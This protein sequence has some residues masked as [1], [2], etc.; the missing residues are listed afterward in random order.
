MSMWCDHTNLTSIPKPEN[1]VGTFHA[2]ADKSS[3]LIF[4]QSCVKTIDKSEF[5]TLK[6]MQTAFDR[7]YDTIKRITGLESFERIASPKILVAVSCCY[8]SKLAFGIF[9]IGLYVKALLAPCTF[10]TEMFSAIQLHVFSD[11]LGD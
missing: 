10:Y 9:C 5:L 7:Y 11:I 1:L 8:A 2:E 6:C 4:A 3:I